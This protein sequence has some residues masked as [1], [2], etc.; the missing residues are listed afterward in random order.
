MANAVN[1]SCWTGV[2]GP[3]IDWRTTKNPVVQDKKLPSYEKNTSHNGFKDAECSLHWSRGATLRS[4][5]KPLPFAVVGTRSEVRLDTEWLPPDPPPGS[6]RALL[7]Q[8]IDEGL[9]PLQLV[10]GSP[11]LA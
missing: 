6:S 9:L 4:L 11:D 10:R 3:Q 2:S 5:S 7:I 8:Y 1:K